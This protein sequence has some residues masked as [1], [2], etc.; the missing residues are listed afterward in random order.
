MF[1][2]LN[3]GAENWDGLRVEAFELLDGTGSGADA[4]NQI[5]Y[6]TSCDQFIIGECLVLLRWRKSERN[7]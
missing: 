6:G 4:I 5:W 1:V 3:R 7:V 2:K